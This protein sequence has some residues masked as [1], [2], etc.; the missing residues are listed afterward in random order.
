MRISQYLKALKETAE[1]QKELGL[2]SLP[3]LTFTHEADRYRQFLHKSEYFK[4]FIVKEVPKPNGQLILMPKDIKKSLMLAVK[5]NKD[6]AF[7]ISGKFN[8]KATKLLFPVPRRKLRERIYFLSEYF[9]NF[10]DY[11]FLIQLTKSIFDKGAKIGNIYRLDLELGDGKLFLYYPK[12]K[13]YYFV[14]TYR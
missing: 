12:K 14:G 6:Q 4:K 2:G 5:E 8:G 3:A 7:E 10:D 13:Q 11:Q 9:Q 1:Y